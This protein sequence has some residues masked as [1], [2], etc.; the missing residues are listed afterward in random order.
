MSALLCLSA[1]PN[2][3]TAAHIARTLV[4]EQLAACVSILPGVQS[5]YRWQGRV[6]QANEVLLLIKSTHERMNEMSSRLTAL[7]PYDV[8]EVL[9]F[10]PDSVL[11]AYLQWL[12]AQTTA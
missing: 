1:C 6:E 10:A 12:Q 4:D 11:P 9:A 8:P 3:E 2:Q 7:H 5:V